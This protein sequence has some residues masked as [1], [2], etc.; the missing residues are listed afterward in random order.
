MLLEMSCVIETVSN[1]HL[2]I[3]ISEVP[4]NSFRCTTAQSLLSMLHATFAPLKDLMVCYNAQSK[5][6]YG[7]SGH[8]KVAITNESS[9]NEMLKMRQTAFRV[10]LHVLSNRVLYGQIRKILAFRYF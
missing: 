7:D 10:R 1:R 8:V 9:Y 6:I 4:K 5:S 2:V 3:K